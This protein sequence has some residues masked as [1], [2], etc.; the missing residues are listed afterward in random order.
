MSYVA[1][2]A[3][4]V[5]L[6]DLPL[7]AMTW[8]LLNPWRGIGIASSPAPL[9]LTSRTPPMALPTLATHSRLDSTISHRA[10]PL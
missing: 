6:E 10:G 9:L 2:A 3:Q 5:T 1:S 7:V 8:P 4:S